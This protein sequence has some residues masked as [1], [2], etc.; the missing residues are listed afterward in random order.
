MHSG[1]IFYLSI[2][3][4]LLCWGLV[5][6]WYVWPWLQSRGRRDALLILITPHAFRYIGL[7][8]LVGGV[9]DPQLPPA[10]AVPA[11]YGD[12]VS[13]LLALVALVALRF[14]VPGAVGVAWVFNVV[15]TGDFLYAFFQGYRNRIK[16]GD[17]GADFFIPTVLV[18]ALLIT[19]LLIFGLLVGGAGPRRRAS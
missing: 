11:A 10:F 1:H 19:H 6:A 2:A 16:P 13:A 8:F 17:L 14:S 7:S 3:F 12:L 9:V 18:P 5:A 4:S 15:G